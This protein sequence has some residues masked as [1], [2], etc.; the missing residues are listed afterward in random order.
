MKRW[1]LTVVYGSA[2]YVSRVLSGVAWRCSRWSIS[3]FCWETSKLTWEKCDWRNGLWSKPDRFFYLVV[4]GLL[5]W[6]QFLCNR[7][8]FKHWGIHKCTLHYN[9]QGCRS[10]VDVVVVS[11]DLWPYVLD[12]YVKKR[13]WAFTWT[14]PSGE[15][16]QMA[17]GDPKYIVRVWWECLAKESIK[18]IFNSQLWQS[19]KFQEEH[20]YSEWAMFHASIV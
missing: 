11:S 12:I 14:S 4:V 10:M 18:R 17:G 19:L 15:L 6:T 5:C 1:A 20:I 7:H 13:S 2:L 8:M 3:L 9:T 16:D